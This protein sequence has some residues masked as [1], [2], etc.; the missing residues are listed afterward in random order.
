MHL[1][2]IRFPRLATRIGTIKY[3]RYLLACAIAALKIGSFGHRTIDFCLRSVACPLRRELSSR[4]GQSGLVWDGHA[5]AA[6]PE[7]TWHRY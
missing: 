5:H 6:G 7:F 1:I 4:G 2:G 3:A